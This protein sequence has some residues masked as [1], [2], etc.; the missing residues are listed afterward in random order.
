MKP[1]VESWSFSALTADEKCPYFT[2]LAKVEKVPQPE[3]DD[4]DHPL[5][6]GDRI[7]KEAENFIKGKGPFTRN[8]R[9]FEET[10]QYYADQFQ[11]GR[12][13]VEEKWGF[14]KEWSPTD[15]KSA[16]LRVVC[17]V[18][19]HRTDEN[20]L[21]VDDWKTGKSFNKQVPHTQQRQLYGISALMRY[22]HIDGVTVR[23]SYLDEGKVSTSDY[24]RVA[25]DG[26]LPKWHERGER[27]TGRMTF[28]PKP[29]RGNCRFCP[30]GPS[31]GNGR[32]VYGV[33]VD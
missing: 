13:E 18:V 25:L 28:P 30:Y 3:P 24:S 22:P 26:L 21:T 16:W 9:K 19:L 10:L 17:D 33:E 20:W 32:C 5:I 8:L 23:M 11:Q 12:V 29:N 14:D 15:W 31:N 6:R 27:M 1:P 7:H 2:Y 4:P